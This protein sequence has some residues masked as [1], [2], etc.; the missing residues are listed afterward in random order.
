METEKNLKNKFTE[1]FKAKFTDI[2]LILECSL[3]ELFF[4]CYKAVSYDRH[5]LLP[6]GISSH[7]EKVEREI[8]IKPGM[9]EKTVIRF[10]KEGNEIKGSFPSDV[11]VTIKEL[12]NDKFSREGDDLVYVHTISLADALKSVPIHF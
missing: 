12:K 3:N 5:T 9:N 11:V 6:D 4:G 1:H 10:A 8:E 7:T 2:N